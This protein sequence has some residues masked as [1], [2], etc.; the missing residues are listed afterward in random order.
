M[1][2]LIFEVFGDN[3]E[4]VFRVIKFAVASADFNLKV[5]EN[6]KADSLSYENSTEPID[7]VLSQIASYKL[8]SAIVYPKES[9]ISYAS[10]HIP[11][12]YEDDINCWGA[13]IEINNINFDGFFIRLLNIEGL[14]IISISLEEG[15]ELNAKSLTLN[16]FPWT[17]N[18]LIVAAILEDNFWQ[19]KLG[20]SYQLIKT[21]ATIN[22]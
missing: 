4:S 14:R 16:S 6:E 13:V 17:Q 3:A 12:L 7:T 15:L 2:Q 18:N 10:I 22:I 8:A 5:L 20:N 21:Y 1:P 19:V 11:N 9:N